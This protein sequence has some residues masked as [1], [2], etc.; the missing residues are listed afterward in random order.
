MSTGHSKVTA[1]APSRHHDGDGAC[2]GERGPPSPVGLHLPSS[3]CSWQREVALL[4]LAKSALPQPAALSSIPF[5]RHLSLDSP[6][7]ESS[8]PLRSL[9]KAPPPCGLWV[10]GARAEE[11]AHACGNAGNIEDG[12]IVWFAPTLSLWVLGSKHVHWPQQGDCTRAFTT[13]RRRRRMP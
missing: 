13:P 12:R 7:C 11:M 10:D 1:H 6:R 5:P 4:L 9:G 8:V 3:W 2:Q